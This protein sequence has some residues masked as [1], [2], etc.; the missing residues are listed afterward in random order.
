LEGDGADLADLTRLAEP[1][2]EQGPDP[3]LVDDLL[4]Q[5]PG[6]EDF[7]DI[8][9]FYDAIQAR[10]ERWGASYSLRSAPPAPL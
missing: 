8:E 9:D 6:E 2:P 7:D 1:F 3:K 4:A 5:R 10:E